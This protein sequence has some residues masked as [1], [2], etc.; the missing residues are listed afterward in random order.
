MIRASIG[1]RAI[2]IPR[3]RH[4][5]RA[6]CRA[7]MGDNLEIELEPELA[8]ELELELDLFLGRDIDMAV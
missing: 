2:S 5:T 4:K 8:S 7:K 6:I 1:A 3:H